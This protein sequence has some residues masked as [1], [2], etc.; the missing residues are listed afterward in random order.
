MDVK[1]EEIQDLLEFF[2]K[3]TYKARDTQPKVHHVMKRCLDLFGVDYTY[4]IVSN[5]N[6]EL[7]TNYPSSLVI[8][9]AEKREEDDLVG[10]EDGNID[11]NNFSSVRLSSSNGDHN[12]SVHS[13]STI[14]SASSRVGGL[15]VS[16]DG[17]PEVYKVKELFGKARFA[18]CRARFPV[19]VILYNNKHICRSAT[20]SGGP[21]IYGRSSFDYF[22]SGGTDYKLLEPDP[23]EDDA[24]VNETQSDWQL[25]DRVRSQDIRLLKTFQVQTIVDLM[26]EKK[27]VKFGVNVT[28]SEKVD[29]ENRYGDFNL[30]SLPYPGCEFFKQYRDNNYNGEELIFEWDQGHVDAHIS[31]PNDQTSSALKLD[32]LQ[33][34][35]WDLIRLTQNYLK[36]L[37][38]YV[39]GGDNGLL[40]HCI[41]GWDRTPL[42]VS[43]LRISLWADGAIHK[44]LSAEQ[45]LYLTLAYDWLLFGHNLEDRL[46]K[47]E[48]ILFFCFYFLK[49]IYPAEF[50]VDCNLNDDDVSDDGTNPV[51]SSNTRH[52]SDINL[53]GVLLDGEG[54]HTSPEGS[55]WSLNSCSSSQS[56]KSQDHPPT[57][58]QVTQDSW[59]DCSGAQHIMNRE[60]P[61]SCQLSSR[62]QSG[63]SS[64]FSTVGT[65]GQTNT[66]GLIANGQ[67]HTSFSGV[68]TKPGGPL[69]PSFSPSASRGQTLIGNRHGRTSPVAVPVPN[70]GFHHQNRTDSN[71]S[72]SIGSWQLI[73]GIGSLKDAMSTSDPGSTYSHASRSSANDILECI[74]ASESSCTL[75]EE[76]LT[77]INSKPSSSSTLNG[78]GS[79]RDSKCIDD[80]LKDENVFLSSS[81]KHENG[82]LS[83]VLQEAARCKTL[84][85]EAHSTLKRRDR[86]LQVRKRFYSTYA[87]TIGQSRQSVNDSGSGLSV[88]IGNI[89]TKVGIRAP[90]H[91]PHCQFEEVTNKF[92]DLL[93]IH[94][95]MYL[96]LLRQGFTS[97][98]KLQCCIN[99]LFCDQHK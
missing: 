47:G 6:G 12:N 13:L 65:N 63:V 57:Y 9:E 27:K 7:S 71:S 53:D 70:R 96:Q 82:S 76:L 81:L 41:S 29:K 46:S 37:L 84:T 93:Y 92:F 86:L 74:E 43:L 8:L 11:L 30:I 56:S 55:N 25:F 90:I 40:I 14:S 68:S 20:L 4:S 94:S 75:V 1:P 50:S 87:A 83:D 73:T 99:I 21:E 89:A 15:S 69:T 22:F 97:R 60:L 78:G 61:T 95:K 64:S 24:I 44:S 88:L 52:D 51:E 98:Q 35:K 48:E 85:E 33:Y 16:Y 31:V 32:W 42:F 49:H 10:R 3:N 19:P 67:N 62:I 79:R 54:C 36:L 77:P 91:H 5:V 80:S 2:S 66:N 59:D 23:T 18:R 58:F 72:A 39:K 38:A 28:S 34:R 45:I 17:N 26:V